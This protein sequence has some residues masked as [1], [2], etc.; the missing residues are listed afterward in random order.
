MLAMKYCTTAFAVCRG[1]RSGSVEAGRALFEVVVRTRRP[2]V[3]LPAVGSKSREFALTDL[4]I[5]SEEFHTSMQELFVHVAKVG[6]ERVDV[7]VLAVPSC[8]AVNGSLDQSQRVFPIWLYHEGS[9]GFV[10]SDG[11]FPGLCVL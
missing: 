6:D 8:L 7:G 4:L 11:R 5:V 1:G 2:N 3:M 9:I 10:V